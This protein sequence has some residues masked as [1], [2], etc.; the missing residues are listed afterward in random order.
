MRKLYILAIISGLF[1]FTSATAGWAQPIRVGAVINLT[2][3]ISSWGKFHAKGHQD[4]FQYVN[5][6]KGGVAGKKIQLTLVD[7]AYKVPE[8]LKFVKKF[9][10]EKVDMIATWDTG[11]GIQAKP[12][13][14]EYKIPTI[15]YSTGQDILKPPID[16]MYL[17]F[18]SYI[19][20][21]YAVMEYIRAVHKGKDAPKVGLLTL[22]NAYGKSVHGPSKEYAAKNNINIITIEEFPAA[23][24]DLSTELLR[25]KQK[26]AEYVFTQILGANMISALKAADRNNYNPLFVGTW[27][28]T[29]PD[30]FKMG[31]GLIRNRLFMQ[32][33]GCV[34]GDK[35]WGM[36]MMEDLWKRYKTV[37]KFDT[38]YWEGV[39]VAMIMERA[40]QRASGL[41]GKISAE[42]IDKAMETFQNEDFGGLV[43]Y[44]SYRKDNHEGSFKGRIVQIH[45]DSTYTPMTNFFVPGKGEIKVLKAPAR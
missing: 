4:Y 36:K 16:Y 25:L 44:V 27:T 17:P 10:E 12:I 20:D 13:I 1:C 30:F 5:D 6:V 24:I 11:L 14:Q 32:F 40:M 21:S 9:G 42:T 38:S 37:D 19:L 2:G 23:T 7:H 29:D 15:N 3:P 43:P 39:V 18:G 33:P 34:P 41:Y 31:Q 35:I 8:G 28:T 45:E 26:G 22:N